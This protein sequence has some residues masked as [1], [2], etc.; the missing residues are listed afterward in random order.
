MLII[1]N[2]IEQGA[3]PNQSATQKMTKMRLI[4]LQQLYD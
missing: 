1:N 4:N 3:Q 2:N